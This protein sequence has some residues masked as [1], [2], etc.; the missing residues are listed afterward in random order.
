MYEDL[1]FSLVETKLMEWQDKEAMGWAFEEFQRDWL[2]KRYASYSHLSFHSM[3]DFRFLNL[4]KRREALEYCLHLARTR[5]FSEKDSYLRELS[6]IIREPDP[7]T[8][9]LVNSASKILDCA[10]A[11]L[12][13]FL[14]NKGGGILMDIWTI[15]KFR[16]EKQPIYGNMEGALDAIKK[17][18]RKHTGYLGLVRQL[19]DLGAD[20]YPDEMFP[21]DFYWHYSSGT[22]VVFLAHP[23]EK[24]KEGW[25]I[26]ILKNH[27]FDDYKSY[28]AFYPGDNISITTSLG[29]PHIKRG[30][31]IKIDPGSVVPIPVAEFYQEHPGLWPKHREVLDMPELEHIPDI[32]SWPDPV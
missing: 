18:R 4:E 24:S 21:E 15:H 17:E 27:S 7:E 28:Y 29:L 2:D 9:F 10:P 19:I 23:R 22:P 26:G 30:D 1:E 11:E 12:E 25:R 13:S 32:L 5:F 8:I 20:G 14:A 3:A 16:D 6:M 31:Y